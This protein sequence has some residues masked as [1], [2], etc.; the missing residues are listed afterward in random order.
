MRRVLPLLFLAACGLESAGQAPGDGGVVDEGIADVYVDR[1]N[2]ITEAGT[3]CACF[4][5]PGPGWT[6]VGYQ[7]D[8]APGCTGSFVAPSPRTAVEA[9]GA[10]A[11]C[12]CACSVLQPATCNI[13]AVNVNVWGNINA[14]CFGNPNATITGNTSCINNSNFGVAGLS[15]AKGTA[16]L[17]PTGGTCNAPATTKNVP[18]AEV[19]NGGVCPLSA[20]LGSGC[21]GSDACVP[22]PPTGLAACVL[23]EN[24]DAACP[25]GYGTRRVVGAAFADTR[26]CGPA[27]TCA[28]TATCTAQGQLNSDDNCAPN[29]KEGQSFALDGAC[30]GISLTGIDDKALETTVTAAPKCDASGYKPTG[31]VA[32]TGGY[33]IC[34]P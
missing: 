9:I 13:T 11:A 27:C 32:P 15:S 28:A 18:A 1:G 6:F 31:G 23:N 20:P 25:A 30:H 16:T 7:R 33:V 22:D 12:T 5:A 2:G 8:G 29:K 10:A 34:C 21:G 14:I 26:D 24:P 17:T 4:P 3:K 19:H